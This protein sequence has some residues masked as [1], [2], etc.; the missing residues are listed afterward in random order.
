[1]VVE[2]LSWDE[3]G[4]GTIADTRWAPERLLSYRVIESLF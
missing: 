4:T 1:M 2:H 3:L